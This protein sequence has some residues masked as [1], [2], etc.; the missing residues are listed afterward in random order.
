MTKAETII[1]YSNNNIGAAYVY[2]GTGKK[3]TPEYRR[4]RIKQ[5]PQYALGITKNCPVLNGSSLD[6]SVCKYQN[7]LAFDCAQLVRRALQNADIILP[8]GASS[9]WL[10]GDWEYKGPIDAKAQEMLC[11]VFREG[12]SP[13]K[14]VG[15]SLGDGF[16]VDARGH[17]TGVIKSKFY[18]YPWTHYAV[19]KGLYDYKEDSIDIKKLQEKLIE[20]GFPL[21]R[22]GAD[23]KFGSETKKAMQNY[24]KSRGMQISPTPQK[25]TYDALL[26]N[27]KPVYVRLQDIES[28]IKK[29]EEAIV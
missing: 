8:S 19:P 21:P 4:A 12:G 5:Y 22:Y 10:R 1:T 26:N 16:V 14:H 23:G 24:Q 20:N 25:P 3:C 18:D 13:M 2:G 11:V 28:R 17:N 7:K 27:E 9:Q 29:L 6:C 15:L